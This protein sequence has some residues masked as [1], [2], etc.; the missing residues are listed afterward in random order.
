M[1]RFLL[2]ISILLISSVFGL[3]GCSTNASTETTF[4]GPIEGWEDISLPPSAEW[5]RTLISGAVE[6]HEYR[7]P[8]SRVEFWKY[9]D[10]GMAFNGWTLGQ[11]KE[12]SR[13]YKKENHTVT[14]TEKEKEENF[15]ILVIIE[16]KGAYEPKG[17][18]DSKKD[19]T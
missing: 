13:V 17:M 15:N 18:E 5:E 14:M 7:I 16:P 9:V 6:N 2:P 11:S 3:T 12:N 8:M 4:S 19:R 1:K 10:E